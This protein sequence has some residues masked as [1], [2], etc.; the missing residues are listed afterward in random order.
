MT[1][2]L[3]PNY[4]WL[5][6]GVE[7]DPVLDEIRVKANG[8]LTEVIRL[9]EQHTRDAL[10]ALGWT[11]PG[12]ENRPAPPAEPVAWRVKDF[13]DG[14]T[15]Y[16]QREAAEREAEST[17]AVIQGLYAAP[18]AP[19]PVVDDAMV[20]RAMSAFLQ[21]NPD[22]RDDWRGYWSTEGL[23][24]CRDQMRTALLAAPGA[25]HE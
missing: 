15:Y 18:P 7:A 10:I 22:F 2:E 3:K 4:S 14:W 20:E 1:S 12:E 24:I 16:R 6:I 9:R 25:G 23:A 11:P 8:R 17:G 19:A 5:T 13:G 21:A